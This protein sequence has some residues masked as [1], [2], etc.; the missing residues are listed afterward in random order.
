[1]WI[2][3]ILE[4]KTDKNLN[5]KKCACLFETAANII[6][7]Q[8]MQNSKSVSS[9]YTI[10]KD[11]KQSPVVFI[12]HFSSIFTVVTFFGRIC[13]IEV[14]AKTCHFITYVIPFCATTCKSKQRFAF[15]GL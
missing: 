7:K 8:Q 3:A 6:T 9:S 1:M 13:R 15:N 2:Q 14:L 12:A 10:P 11:V 4:K 5:S